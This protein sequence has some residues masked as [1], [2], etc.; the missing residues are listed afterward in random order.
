MHYSNSYI[1]RATLAVLRQ[2]CTNI[3]NLHN[4]YWEPLFAAA[5]ADQPPICMHI[6]SGGAAVSLEGLNSMTEI[7][8][9]FAYAARSSVNPMVSPLLRKYPDAR[10][11]WS[12]GPIR[13]GS[14]T[15]LIAVV[16]AP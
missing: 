11:V 2:Q 14:M 1:T 10:V 4:G 6:G 15:S 3:M 16:T 5:R 7:A 12:E 9:A 13:A 8:A